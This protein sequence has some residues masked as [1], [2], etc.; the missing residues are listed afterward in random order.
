M[1]HG[2]D[3]RRMRFLQSGPQQ[4]IGNRIRPGWRS[5][6]LDYG[7]DLIG[8]KAEFE[9][10]IVTVNGWMDN[11]DSLDHIPSHDLNP[12]KARILLMLAL[13]QID[14]VKTIAEYFRN[15]LAEFAEN[16]MG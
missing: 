7:H 6:I 15:Y 5:F 4:Y 9:N 11:N 10:E 12:Q 2:H 14:D 16:I 3:D 1:S 13:T 8:E